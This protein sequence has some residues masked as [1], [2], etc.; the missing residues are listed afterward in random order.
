MPSGGGKHGDRLRLDWMDWG[1]SM[2]LQLETVNQLD[3]LNT[4]L[5]RMNGGKAKPNPLLPP[6]ADDK[7][8]T[9]HV[10]GGRMSFDDFLSQTNSFLEAL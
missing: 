4:N 10:A 2:M 3:R 6:G 8:Q 9:P 5:I 1:Q 7:P